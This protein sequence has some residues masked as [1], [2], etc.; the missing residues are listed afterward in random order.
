M[1]KIVYFFVIFVNCFLLA[2]ETFPKK[3]HF[4][5]T[6][7]DVVPFFYGEI[8]QPGYGLS[9]RVGNSGHTF[10]LAPFKMPPSG[11]RF[12]NSS[13]RIGVTG[14]Y[15]YVF[16][17]D[18]IL[19]PYLGF[20]LTHLRDKHSHMSW[21]YREGKFYSKNENENENEKENY[22]ENLIGIQICSPNDKPTKAYLFTDI[23]GLP[24]CVENGVILE[25]GDNFHL[26]IGAGLS[27]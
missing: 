8:F 3:S 9:I 13:E 22:F 10:E 12:G 20:S 19:Q 4:Q 24:L 17:Q 1:K 25:S 16:R 2:Q 26:R 15:Y 21:Y 27:F 5:K 11:G 7:Y 6:R 23:L 18:S 14:S